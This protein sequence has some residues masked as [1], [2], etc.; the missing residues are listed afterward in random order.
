MIVELNL[1]NIIFL[2]IALV[3][4][5]WA[6]TKLLVAQYNKALDKRFDAFAETMAEQQKSLYTLERQFLMLQ[7]E[8]PR[9]YM[10]RDDFAREIKS[11]HEAVQRDILPMRQSV[12]R[13]EDFL[14]HNK[15]SL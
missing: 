1:S 12:T 7:S 10:R 9:E 13:I 4:A 2:A 15:A 14:L 8:L 3:G 5:F 11:L 6:L